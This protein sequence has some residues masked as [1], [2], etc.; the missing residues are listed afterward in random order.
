MSR[1]KTSVNRLDNLRKAFKS[2]SGKVLSEKQVFDA[3]GASYWRACIKDL[4]AEGMNIE[5]VRDGRTV[6]GYKY[7]DIKGSSTKK[8]EVTE[9]AEA[10]AKVAASKPKSAKKPTKGKTT[11]K[12]TKASKV[13]KPA[14]AAKATEP[15]VVGI[16]ETAPED[17]DP[18]VLAILRQAGL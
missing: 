3:V 4:K 9:A 13:N 17:E 10:P 16:E 11:T 2:H 12:P 7:V 8:A 5:S 6:I 18:E 1:P 14:K 15:A